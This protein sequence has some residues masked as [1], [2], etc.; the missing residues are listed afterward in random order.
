M[1]GVAAFPRPTVWREAGEREW[2]GTRVH[3]SEVYLLGALITRS[4]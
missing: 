1:F 2:T 4:R 3:Y